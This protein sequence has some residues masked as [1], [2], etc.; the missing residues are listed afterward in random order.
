MKYKSF[1]SS[2]MKGQKMRKANINLFVFVFILAISFFAFN[3]E[4]ISA[5]G[6]EI[7]GTMFDKNSDGEIT[8]SDVVV[9]GQVTTKAENFLKVDLTSGTK[10]LT[11]IQGN[12][13][14]DKVAIKFT[15]SDFPSDVTSFMIVESERTD[16]SSLADADRYNKDSVTGAWVA[17]NKNVAKNGIT[18]S[19]LFSTGEDGKITVD[20]VYRLR[21]GTFGMK[22]L[23][24]YCYR[25]EVSESNPT[26][27]HDVAYVIAQPIDMVNQSS[28][29]CTEKNAA[30]I[31]VN[32]D[33][34][35]ATSRISK[36]LKIYLPVS[37]AYNFKTVDVSWTYDATISNEVINNYNSIVKCSSI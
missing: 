20:V 15:I 3:F 18:G 35:G 8:Q 19:V 4:K 11:F 1:I 14:N 16:S 9:D 36:E 25:A 5:M 34:D 26:Y 6:T 24:I 31:C 30:E 29:T 13:Q 21:K 33:E 2:N 10:K 32:Y 37:V 17:S 22:F 7:I 12:G 28:D 27:Q 23:K